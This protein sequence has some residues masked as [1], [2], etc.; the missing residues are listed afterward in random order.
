MSYILEARH[1]DLEEDG[2]VIYASNAR[3]F[4][5]LLHPYNDKQTPVD[6]EYIVRVRAGARSG[7][8]GKPVYM[9]IKKG[10]NGLMG[11]VLVDAPIDEPRVY[12]VRAVLSA[13][14]GGELGVGIV[15]GARFTDPNFVGMLLGSTADKEFQAGKRKKASQLRARARAEGVYSVNYHRSQFKKEIM[16]LESIPKLYIDYVELEGPVGGRWP[17]ESRKLIYEP[18]GNDR[19][20][21]SEEYEPADAA[22][23]ASAARRIIATWLPK[24]FRRPVANS[25]IDALVTVVEEELRNGKTFEEALKTAFVAMLCSPDFLYLFEPAL[26]NAPVEQRRLTDVELASRLSYFIWSSMPDDELARHAE[27]GQLRQPEIFTAQI[28]RMIQDSRSDALVEDFASQWLKISE[29]DRF[30]PDE[31][32]FPDYYANQFVGIGED[33][34]R[35][36]L[37]FFSR[38]AAK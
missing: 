2:M 31:R 23:A 38:A 17:P 16:D 9:D 19:P 20:D 11:R 24:A 26:P 32:I 10:A 8:D 4:A 7:S 25:E 30:Q 36:P 18:L 3:T 15:D 13:A 35:E 28:D 22:D 1:A 21:P 29:F 6:G 34:N 12:E 33:M 37:A 5:R 27:A 14:L